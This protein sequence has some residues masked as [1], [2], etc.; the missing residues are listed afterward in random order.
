MRPMPLAPEEGGGLVR[1]EVGF[2]SG[3]ESRTAG[4]EDDF[5]LVG[6]NG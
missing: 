2:A 5:A 3:R 6:G 1:G 4:D